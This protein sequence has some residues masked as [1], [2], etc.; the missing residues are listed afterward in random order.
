MARARGRRVELEMGEHCEIVG[1]RLLLTDR[2]PSDN[3]LT[4][5]GGDINTLLNASFRPCESTPTLSMPLSSIKSRLEPH[6]LL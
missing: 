2:L 6:R 4:C 3:H 1:G 5:K